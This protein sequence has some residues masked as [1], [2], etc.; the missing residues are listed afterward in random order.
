MGAIGVSEEVGYLAIHNPAGS[1]DLVL[2]GAS[3]PYL[4]RTTTV[5][6]R[7]APVF[8][9][10]LR[11]EEERSADAETFHADEK[12]DVLILG[13]H[14]FAQEVSG[15]GWDT[16]SLRRLDPDP[17]LAMEWGT[18]D[19]VGDDWITVPLMR[20]YLDPVVIVKPM[21]NDGTLPGVIRT[22]NV[23]DRSFEVRQQAWMYMT[24]PNGPERLFYL[25]AERGRHDLAGLTFEAGSLD[26]KKALGA[27]GWAQV[28]FTGP[29]AE[30]PVVFAAVETFRG[31]QPVVT[32]IKERTATGFKMAMQEEQNSDL[33]H[34]EETLGWIAIEAGSGV[35]SGGRRV[36]V[37]TSVADSS[38]S[39]TGF[40]GTFARRFPFILAGVSSTYGWDTCDVRYENLTPS[41]VDLFLV[42]E[43]SKDVEMS[44]APEEVSVFVAE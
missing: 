8:S 15:V 13:D 43:Q 12:A 37:L 9:C 28:S 29:F 23:G 4:L 38:S 44:H 31:A 11:F 36:E 40:T 2:D 3:S 18:I 20:T 5:D 22:R 27:G 42:E 6:E 1:G 25:V 33:F 19:A 26:T 7:W 16:G 30:A 39:T 32:R 41:G 10:S 21:S 34:A 24:E 14:L 35:T 17:S